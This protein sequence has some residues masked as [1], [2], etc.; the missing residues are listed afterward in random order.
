MISL[1]HPCAR[2]DLVTDLLAQG[3]SLEEVEQEEAESAL[4]FVRR[5]RVGLIGDVIA[6]Q[7]RLIRMLRGQ[8]PRPEFV[9]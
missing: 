4:A 2:V 9:R 5:I 7:L 1:S 6:T 3:A 8:T